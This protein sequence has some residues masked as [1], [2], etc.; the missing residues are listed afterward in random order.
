MLSCL[1]EN[2]LTTDFT[3]MRRLKTLVLLS[4]KIAESKIPEAKSAVTNFFRK[5]YRRRYNCDQPCVSG[6]LFFRFKRVFAIFDQ[7]VV[8][9]IKQASEFNSPVNF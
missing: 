2:D 9:V 3:N 4:L 8:E 7:P 5:E 1:T 6:W